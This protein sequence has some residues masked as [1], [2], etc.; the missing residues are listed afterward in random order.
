[1]EDKT[2][3]FGAPDVEAYAANSITRRVTTSH[4]VL[5]WM[6]VSKDVLCAFSMGP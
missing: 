4:I 5:G 2:W 3:L 6:L 1:M